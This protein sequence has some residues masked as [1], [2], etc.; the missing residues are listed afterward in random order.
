MENSQI[1]QEILSAM[2]QEL[3]GWLEEQSKITDGYE[4]ESKYM[5]FAQR[6][7]NIV[8]QK[9]MGKVPGSRNKKKLI[10]VLEK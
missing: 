4:Y 3:D 2:S 1:K 8:L 10:H 7:N 5:L 9:S 6:M